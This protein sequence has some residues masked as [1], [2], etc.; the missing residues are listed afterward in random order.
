MLWPQ[1]GFSRFLSLSEN[2]QTV[3]F[4]TKG[5]RSI[6]TQIL[7]PWLKREDN[8]KSRLK[9][10]ET[11]TFLAAN[12]T[13]ERLLLFGTRI[14]TLRIPI[15]I[16]GAAIFQDRFIQS[17]IQQP[18]AP[19]H[20]NASGSIFVNVFPILLSARNIHR[21]LQVPVEQP[22]DVAEPGDLIHR[23]LE[24]TTEA[25]ETAADAGGSD[26]LIFWIRSL[27]N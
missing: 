10:Q 11:S 19:I 14:L 3:L 23:L 18:L 5:H 21:R 12:L 17:N 20:T 25:A 4:W 8:F 6:L 7:F 24:P 1:T 13:S 26:E 16:F 9:K 27:V 22:E 2:G 15:Q